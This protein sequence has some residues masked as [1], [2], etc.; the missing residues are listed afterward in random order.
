MTAAFD[1]IVIGAGPAGSHA[2]MAAAQGGLSVALI[3]E[4]GEPGGQIYRAP[5]PGF[6]LPASKQDADASA[7]DDL[8]RKVSEASVDWFP[9]RR[10]WSV[11][12]G[13]RVDSAGANGSE[14]FTAP[15]LVAATGAHERVVPF[16]GWTL[17]GVIGLAAATI[18][19]KSQ[20]MLP[21]RRVVIAGCGPLLAAVA[22][23]IATAGGDIVAVVDLAGPS[24]WLRA[25]P[26]MLRRP[27]LLARGVGWSL[28]LGR[29]RV[30]IYFRHTV[31]AADGHGRV[32]RVSIEPVDRNGALL[33]G[34]VTAFDVDTLVVGHGL[35]PGAEIPRLLRADMSY[36]RRRGGWIPKI[37]PAGRTSIRGLFAIG[38]GAGIRGAEPAALAGQIAGLSAVIDSGRAPRQLVTE[39]LAALARYAPFADAVSNL[40]ALRPAQVAAI[41]AATVV[42]RCEDVTRGEIDAAARDGA[43][44]LNQLKHFTRC[45]MGP[46][47]GRMCGDVAAELLALARG[48]PREGV[49]FWTGRPPLR[50]MPLDDLAGTFS[51]S[52]IPIPKPAP[53]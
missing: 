10:V 9:G 34:H 23:K 45:G 17:P 44:D 27:K 38:D 6:V 12:T 18:L 19:I 25:M 28:T 3:D 41:S 40:M 50:P 35:V 22:G 53:L 39:K 48:V 51:Y 42:C 26:G 2:A 21:G 13:F 5:A 47:Q 11:S 24:D 20:G 49:G 31:K 32:E 8:R 15:Q 30:P 37:D 1:L 7:G 43:H 14:T 36:D 29:K 46:C 16:P 4:T 52:D 33:L